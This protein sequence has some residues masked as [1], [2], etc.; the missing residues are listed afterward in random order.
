MIARLI[1]W[2]LG[3]SGVAA[4]V[5]NAAKLGSILVAAP[6]AWSWFQGHQH[7]VVLTLD[8]SQALAIVGVVFAML[9]VAHI[10]RGPGQ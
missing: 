10:A 8:V 4:G 3:G 5:T 2:L 6:L 1:E 9:Q 7:D